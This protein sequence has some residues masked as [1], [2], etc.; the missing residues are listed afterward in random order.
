MRNFLGA[1]TQCMTDYMK[2][3]IRVKP[4]HFILHVVTNDLN[5]K[6][7]P[8][9]IAKAIIDVASELASE[10]TG[11]SISSIITRADNE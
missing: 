1:T 8:D 5:S 7:P 11:V 10:K 3:S 6:R 4:N 2:P 9:E